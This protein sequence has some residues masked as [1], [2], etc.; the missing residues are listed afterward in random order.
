MMY[1]NIVEDCFFTPHHV[2]VLDVSKPFVVCLHREQGN[3]MNV[4]DLYLRCSSDQVVTRACFK[5]NGNPFA[6]AALEW[7]CRRTEGK[8]IANL[9][10]C[11]HQML[12]QTLDIPT[13]QYPI[14]VYLEGIYKDALN[15]MIKKFER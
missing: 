13:R 4:V 15:L 14:A 10:D 1:N 5:S 8:D 7:L 3:R 2:D 12:I 6:I 9:L 11:N